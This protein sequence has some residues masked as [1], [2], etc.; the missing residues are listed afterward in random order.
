MTGECSECVYI[1]E[2]EHR[3]HA[4]DDPVLIPCPEFVSPTPLRDVDD[5]PLRFTVEGEL[6]EVRPRLGVPGQYDFDWVSGPN[7]GYGFTSATSDGSAESRDDL[8]DAIRDFLSM[9]DPETGYISEDE[10]DD[11]RD[12]CK[13]P[14]G[15]PPS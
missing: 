1:I 6:F 4:D 13:P 12:T 11:E 15:W 14:L 5:G 8:E 7:D 9:I 10:D 2:H 3:D